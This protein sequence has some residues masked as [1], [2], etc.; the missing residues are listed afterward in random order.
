MTGYT[1]VANVLDY[2]AVV[3]QATTADKAIDLKDEGITP[4]SDMDGLI[5]SHCKFPSHRYQSNTC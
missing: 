3:V 1:A 5:A 4:L 2:S